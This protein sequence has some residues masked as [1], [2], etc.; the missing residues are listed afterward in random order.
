MN[1][2]QHFQLIPLLK[3]WCTLRPYSSPFGFATREIKPLNPEG[4]QESKGQQERVPSSER[5]LSGKMKQKRWFSK[6]SKRNPFFF[7]CL[8]SQGFSSFA[9]KNAPP[10]PSRRSADDSTCHKLTQVLVGD[11]AIG[12]SSELQSASFFFF[13]GGCPVDSKILFSKH[14]NQPLSWIC[15]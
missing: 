14:M 1:L 4:E 6:I 13:F 12:G 10:P 9:E 7:G 8:S 5:K 2:S 11:P 3:R 15:F